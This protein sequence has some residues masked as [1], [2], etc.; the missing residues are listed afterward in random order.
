MMYRVSIKESL[1][2]K[3]SNPINFTNHVYEI[4]IF[5]N[6]KH[7]IMM[8]RKR[9]NFLYFQFTRKW[10][11]LEKNTICVTTI[12]STIPKRVQRRFGDERSKQNNRLINE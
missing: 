1:D 3:R 9:V 10:R 12:V 2:K 11:H 8:L 5:S 6:I 4:S 7:Y